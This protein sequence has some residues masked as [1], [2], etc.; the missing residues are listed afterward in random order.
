MCAPKSREMFQSG[1]ASRYRRFL[2]LRRTPLGSSARILLPLRRAGAAHAVFS[3]LLQPP[4][5]TNTP[6]MAN[7]TT[8]ATNTTITTLTQ[9]PP[10]PPRRHRPQRQRFQTISGCNR[11]RP[12]HVNHA[13]PTPPLHPIAITPLPERGYA[14]KR[15][16][17]PVR[18][19]VCA[20]VQSQGREEPRLQRRL[21][22][23]GD[24]DVHKRKRQ[25]IETLTGW[26]LIS[27]K[28]WVNL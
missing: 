19:V 23:R 27:G 28:G 1:T 11:C 20:R 3:T 6:S 22:G 26:S 25:S 8:N 10:L 15:L 7:T 4:L 2:G 17:H 12:P 13:S 16:P 24:M 5:A 21:S 14:R 9:P 18:G